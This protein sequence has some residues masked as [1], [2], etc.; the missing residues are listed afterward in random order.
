MA[1]DYDFFEGDG[2]FQD[3]WADQFRVGMGIDHPLLM[4]TKLAAL[5]G[6][7]KGNLAKMQERFFKINASDEEKYAHVLQAVF[8]NYYDI[9][10]PHMGRDDLMS[11]LDAITLI[12]DIYFKNPLGYLLGY[13]IVSRQK[14]ID[15]K[16]LEESVKVIKNQEIGSIELIRYSR[17]WINYYERHK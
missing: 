1:D 12:P 16:R 8:Y 17:L 9:L 2:D 6:G 14:K 5:G 11:M 13:Y 10:N 15:R 4:N 7:G 3:N